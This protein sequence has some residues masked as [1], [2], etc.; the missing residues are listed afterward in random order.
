LI[1]IKTIVIKQKESYKYIFL[2]HD[3]DNRR[4]KNIFSLAVT[5]T[6]TNIM[7]GI[8]KLFGGHILNKSNKEIDLNKKKYKGMIIGLYFSAH[9]YVWFNFY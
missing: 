8:A 2:F 7:A 1:K 3:H 4:E 5:H 6:H 9:W